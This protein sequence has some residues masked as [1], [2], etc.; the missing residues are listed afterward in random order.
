MVIFGFNSDI[1]MDDAIYHVQSEWRQKEELLQ[2]QVFMGGDCIGKIER[3]CAET[4]LQ[5]D[6]PETQLHEMLKAQHLHILETIRQGQA[7]TLF[8]I[9]S[10]ELKLEWTG[11]K[12][13]PEEQVVVLQFRVTT[14][15]SPLAGVPVTVCLDVPGRESLVL[16][17]ETADSGI[18]E[19]RISWEQALLAGGTLLV[20][21]RRAQQTCRGRFRLCIK[22]K[23]G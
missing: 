8:E 12:V 10:T 7:R 13:L 5:A 19:A 9:P 18:A 22:P 6:C 3:P 4:L 1:K 20:Q 16:H 15:E 21:A 14:G 2:T 11:S 23:N 17:S